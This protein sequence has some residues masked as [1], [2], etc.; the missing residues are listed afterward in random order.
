MSSALTDLRSF[1]ISNPD[2]VVV[3]INQDEGVSP[4]NIRRAFEQ[5][6]LLDLVYRGQLGPFPTLRE[7]IDSN[8]RLVV[9]AEN[10]AGDI[11]WYH[12]A[13]RNALQETPYRFRT[14]AALK[15]YA[16][17]QLACGLEG[18]ADL[19]GRRA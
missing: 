4:A 16:E 14:T 3:V 18:V 7:M 1:L 13:Y 17:A 8:Q 15:Q 19:G 11:P 9:M 2:A 12:L 5:A 10:D 6:G